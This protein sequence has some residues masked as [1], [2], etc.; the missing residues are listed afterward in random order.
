MA[1]LPTSP[2]VPD[3]DEVRAWLDKT[4]A[5]MQ[6]VTLV[7]AIVALLTRMRDANTALVARVAELTRRRPRHGGLARVEAQLSLVF[8]EAEA[9][10]T[11]PRT[12]C[13]SG[14]AENPSA[15]IPVPR[16]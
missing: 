5:A 12:A 1:P 15:V 10:E 3:L 2:S 13:W 14:D 11:K 7:T 16:R 9:T 8:E 4:I 6:F